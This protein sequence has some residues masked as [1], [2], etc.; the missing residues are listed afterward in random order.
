MV[1]RLHYGWVI[2]L[3]SFIALL[4]VQGVRLSFGAF[5]QPW[6]NEFSTDRGTISFIAMLSF[7]VYGITQPIV[8]KLI[9]RLGVRK[10]ISFS[11]LIVGLSIIMTFFVTSTWELMLLYGVIGSIGF[12]G[13]SGVAA[14]VAVT[15][16]FVKK[17]GLAL[18]M[19]TAGTSAGQLVLVPAS[20]LLV[21]SVG[22]K[23]TVL[24]LGALLTVVVFPVLLLFFRNSPS[25]KGVRSY[26]E[27][28]GNPSDEKPREKVE[29]MT[30][31][32]IRTRIFWF[33]ALPFFVCGYTTSGLMD[34]HLIPYAHDHGFSTDVTGAAVSL[35]A[36]FN[37]VGTLVSGQIADYWNNRRF[38]GFLYGMRGISII[39]LMVTDQPYLLFAFAILF[40]LV[41]FATVAPTSMLAAEYFKRYSVGMVIGWLY[42]SHQVGSALGAY[43][44]G[45]LYDWTG[46]YSFS[47]L[48]A[49]VL[50]AGASILSLLLPETASM[51]PA[52]VQEEGQQGTSV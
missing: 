48:S 22:W 2:L 45:V 20:L 30:L 35:L 21:E 25:E 18:G 14:S 19:I 7:I 33:L 10:T 40:G 32:G 46:G 37:I 1:K 36:A 26:G 39:L 41:D 11:A 38:L 49:I 47:L 34:T 43:I 17:R 52:K 23:P 13:A 6:E 50:L 28:L 3:L 16:W 12:G 8:G 51:N 9:D 29:D 24:I 4:S 5:I 42:L 44:P 31:R 27:D 15:H